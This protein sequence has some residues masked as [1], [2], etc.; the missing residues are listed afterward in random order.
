MRPTTNAATPIKLNIRRPFLQ[1][2]M[3]RPKTVLTIH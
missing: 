2:Q 3:H 1:V